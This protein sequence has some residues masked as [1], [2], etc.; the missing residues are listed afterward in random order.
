[1]KLNAPINVL[2]NK[3]IAVVIA[4]IFHHVPTVSATAKKSVDPILRVLWFL[5]CFLSLSQLIPALI[6]YFCM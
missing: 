3:V 1:M 2:P 4:L 5:H 6:L